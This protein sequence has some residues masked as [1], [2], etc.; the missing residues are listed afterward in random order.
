M[1]EELVGMTESRKWW[2]VDL[3]ARKEIRLGSPQFKLV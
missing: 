2:P 1:R 3:F